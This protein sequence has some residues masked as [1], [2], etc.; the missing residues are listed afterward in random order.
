MPNRQ[1][2]A[3]SANKD[4]GWVRRIEGSA[5]ILLAQQHGKMPH[6]RGPTRTM[7]TRARRTDRE[8]HGLS[9]EGAKASGAVGLV[10]SLLAD[11]CLTA[12]RITGVRLNS[13][14]SSWR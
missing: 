6:T 2:I 4:M 11:H 8:T 3:A 5:R 14:S 10:K 7:I 12:A 13:Q 9:P 1:P